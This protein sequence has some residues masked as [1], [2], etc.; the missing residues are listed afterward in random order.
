M[1]PAFKAQ[2][3]RLLGLKFAPPTME[4]HWA[5]LSHLTDE[6]LR[7]A[8]SVAQR[9]CREFPT[10]SELLGF[11][12]QSSPRV[13]G[14]D[15]F[16]GSF[17]CTACQDSGWRRWGCGDAAEKEELPRQHCGRERTHYG[18]LWVDICPCRATNPAYLRKRERTVQQAASRTAGKKDAA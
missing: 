14:A 6:Q 17:H 12:E 5:A 4:T 2:M 13:Y 10:P 9:E 16:D 11:V 7:D 15:A 3:S 1:T 8:I 18:H